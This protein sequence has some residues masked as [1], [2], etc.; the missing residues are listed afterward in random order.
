MPFLSPPTLSTNS[1]LTVEPFNPFRKPGRG[2]FL[3][4]GGSR[5]DSQ[6]SLLRGASASAVPTRTGRSSNTSTF[7]RRF[8]AR[9]TMSE[10]QKEYCAQYS[11]SCSWMAGATFPAQSLVALLRDDGNHET[12][13]DAQIAPAAEA[14]KEGPPFHAPTLPTFAFWKAS[15]KS[16]PKPGSPE[17]PPSNSW[18]PSVRCPNHPANL[19][20]SLLNPQSSSVLRPLPSALPSSILNPQWLGSPATSAP[21]ASIP[22]TSDSA[23]CAPKATTSPISPA[24]SPVSSRRSHLSRQSNA[25][26][27]TNA[28][29]LKLSNPNR[30]E[31]MIAR[32][33]RRAR[34]LENTDLP[35]KKI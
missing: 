29:D 15:A 27:G 24:P 9:R 16:S 13:P 4:W 22:T 28:D 30:N 26:A 19:Q 25:A 11:E 23:V 31:G 3:F 33:R 21:S 35:A 7:S 34:V 18:N 10:R 6:S 17:S 8:S 1:E 32:P 20:S 12:P 2:F 14:A 5:S